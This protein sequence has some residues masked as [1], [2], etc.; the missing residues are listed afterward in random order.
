MDYKEAK[1]KIDGLKKELF[2][3]LVESVK[4]AVKENG[5]KISPFINTLH[6]N[7][8]NYD[9]EYGDHSTLDVVYY[10]PDTDELGFIIWKE[11][12][13]QEKSYL[14]RKFKIYDI[15]VLQLIFHYFC[16]D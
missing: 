7:V 10:I 4:N 16:E 5:E 3:I 13:T 6:L 15:D 8:T 14:C 1:E 11:G 2:D 12:Y 9:I